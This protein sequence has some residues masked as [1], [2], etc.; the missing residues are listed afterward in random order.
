MAGGT[1]STREASGQ[2]TWLA[3][4]AHE[5]SPNQDEAEILR[6]RICRHPVV[7]RDAELVR[8]GGDVM[9]AKLDDLTSQGAGA[10]SHL[11]QRW[12][13]MDSNHRYPAFFFG[14]PQFTF[15]NVNT[16]SL[17]TTNPTIWLQ[18]GGTAIEFNWAP[19]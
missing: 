6:P 2:P 15:R 5:S 18:T 13:E 1:T 4:M 8:L 17:A 11:P 10:G 16:G 12:R 9:M 3:G 19:P 14:C 7:Q